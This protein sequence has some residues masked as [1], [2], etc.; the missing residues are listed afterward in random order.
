MDAQ[1][2]LVLGIGNPGAAY[3]GTRHN[4]GFEVLD[5]LA[6]RLA[7]RFEPAAGPSEIARGEGA[8]GPFALLKPLGY[9]NLSGEVLGGLLRGG[10]IECR[11]GR[12]LVVVDDLALPPGVLRLRAG[13]SDGGHNGLKSIIRQLGTREF[14]RLRVGIG[15]SP[16]GDARDHVLGVFSAEERPGVDAAVERCVRGIEALLAGEEFL[17]VQERLNRDSLPADE[18]VR[19]TGTPAVATCVAPA[20]PAASHGRIRNHGESPVTTKLKKYEGM[21]LLHNARLA[22]SEVAPVARVTELLKRQNIEPLRI[23]VWDERRLAYPISGQK[24]GTYVLTHFEAP[25]ES[26]QA[27]NR[28]VNIT[29]DILRALITVHREKFPDFKTAAEMEASRPRRDDDRPPEDGGG[30]FGQRSRRHATPVEDD[31]ASDDGNGDDGD[32]E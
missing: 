6:A 16:A 4:V 8:G 3:L 32:S 30:R 15:G 26:I 28:D 12:L 27:I 10:F 19:E 21:F 22:E 17:R 1:G 2:W 5:R 23:A 13:G 9:V 14:P 18:R 24:R 7:V 29:E 31:A 20:E 25:P 11:P